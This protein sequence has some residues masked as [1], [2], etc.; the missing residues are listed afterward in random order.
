MSPPRPGGWAEWLGGHSNIN[1]IELECPTRDDEMQINSGLSEEE[2]HF[3]N[4]NPK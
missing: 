2:P 1:L 3:P 4:P